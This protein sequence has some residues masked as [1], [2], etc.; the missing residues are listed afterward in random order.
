MIYAP[1]LHDIPPFRGIK[2]TIARMC[3]ATASAEMTSALVVQPFRGFDF[4]SFRA[5][6]TERISISHNDEIFS[7]KKSLLARNAFP[8]HDNRYCFLHV[9]GIEM[10]LSEPNKKYDK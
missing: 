9:F 7:P 10:N 5:I 4:H 3:D 1:G 2:M 6:V 8:L